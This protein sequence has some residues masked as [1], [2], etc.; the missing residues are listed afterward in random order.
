MVAAVTYHKECHCAYDLLFI[1]VQYPLNGESIVLPHLQSIGIYLAGSIADK[2]L[3]NIYHSRL[4]IG[5][6]RV[7]AWH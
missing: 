3:Q 6:Q 2:F 1:D 7:L 5:S 4:V